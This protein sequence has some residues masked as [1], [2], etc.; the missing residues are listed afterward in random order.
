MKIFLLILA[1][2][3]QHNPD[4]K[5]V[6]MHSRTVMG[7]TDRVVNV[8]DD[9]LPPALLE[10][11]QWSGAAEELTTSTDHVDPL[12]ST[13]WN[14]SAPYNNLCP[15]YEAGSKSATGCVATAMAQVMAYWQYPTAQFDWDHM[16][17]D[18]ASLQGQ[19][20]TA[21][22]KQAVAELMLSCG[23]SV[24]M[25]YNKSSGASFYRVPVAMSG[26]Y[27][28]NPGTRHVLRQHMS[29]SEWADLLRNELRNGRPV[30]Y[31]G[32]SS[33]SGHCFVVDGFNED[34]FFHVNWGWGGKSD[35][36]Y[37]FTMLTPPN[38]G[39][40]GSTS[41]DGYNTD[42]AMLLGLAPAT[43]L[44]TPVVRQ[45]EADTLGLY[46]TAL[47]R[48]S[49]RISGYANYSAG[50]TI[51]GDLGVALFQNGTLLR[52]ISYSTFTRPADGSWN[53][54][55][56]TTID[57]LTPGQ[58]YQLIVV[59][60]D[61]QGIPDWQIV[62]GINHAPCGRTLYATSSNT[63][64]HSLINYQGSPLCSHA[65][66]SLLVNGY[67]SFVSTVWTTDSSEWTGRIAVALDNG[68]D[69]QFLAYSGM[70]LACDRNDT[71]RIA[72]ASITVPEGNYQ[73][74]TGYYVG[75]ALHW[76]PGGETVSVV[77]RTATDMIYPVSGSIVL[78]DTLISDQNPNLEMDFDMTLSSSSAQDAFFSGLITVGLYDMQNNLLYVP[79]SPVQVL[80][81]KQDLVSLHFEGNVA[82]YV[83]D[84]R[85]KVLVRRRPA[86]NSG[87]TY[88]SSESYT[89]YI[90]V[91][92]AYTDIQH[93]EQTA[94]SARRV[95][96]N[97]RIYIVVNH[98]AYDILGH[99][100]TIK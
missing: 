91:S 71:L 52:M 39:I 27:G 92:H 12:L 98:R 69:F 66:T 86:G 73:L 25:D 7:Y 35:G 53:R 72:T 38:Q 88:L 50:D 46:K 2:L 48:D 3:V 75:S 54:S 18:Y 90:T 65:E 93:S 6:F 10:W 96:C 42:Q 100:I 95:L 14:Q 26:V 84:G 62:Y 81:A 37:R 70:D 28:Y 13:R 83:Q 16:L 19:N 79:C 82:D 44:T 56:R 29:Y 57:G 5:R 33:S 94:D 40:G 76:F 1:F 20:A 67:P 64:T 15:E 32:H 51:T 21:E 47:G 55:I 23:E 63:Y 41:T 78:A 30:L 8:D 34:G 85:Y 17:A 61:S 22:Q 99:H 36:W 24:M 89:N 68:T 74:R 49:I 11:M 4:G 31:S 97:G 45:L 58:T 59:W 80:C 43:T 9:E 60:R 87:Y 77:S